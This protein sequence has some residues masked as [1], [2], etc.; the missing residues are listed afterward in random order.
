MGS[1]ATARPGNDAVPRLADAAPEAIQRLRRLLGALEEREPLGRDD[2]LGAP[3]GAA[4]EDA[5]QGIEA[6]VAVP[7]V[8]DQDRLGQPLVDGRAD[9]AREE[10]AADKGERRVARAG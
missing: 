1:P 8:E 2:A 6:D 7:V 5:G 9:V 4:L 3:V 10:P